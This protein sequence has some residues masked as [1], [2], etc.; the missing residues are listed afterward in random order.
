MD[1]LLEEGGLP[2]IEVVLAG[3]EVVDGAVG[4]EGAEDDVEEAE[5]GTESLG[6]TIGCGDHGGV[7]L[8][9]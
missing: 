3:E 8:R 5:Q 9:G 2:E 1:G 4:G 7:T 6:Q